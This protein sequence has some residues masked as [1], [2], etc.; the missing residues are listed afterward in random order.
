MELKLLLNCDKTKWRLFTMARRADFNSL[1]TCSENG[2][3]L[4]RVTSYKYLHICLDEKPDFFRRIKEE[5]ASL[6]T[7]LSL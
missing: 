2:A 4:E 5:N 3:G 7:A 1:K 6:K